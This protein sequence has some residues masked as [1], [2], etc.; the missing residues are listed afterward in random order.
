MPVRNASPSFDLLDTKVRRWVWKQG[1]ASLNQLQEKAIPK[2]LA[3]EGDVILAAPTAGGKTE[4]AFLPIISELCASPEALCVCVSPLKALI[5]DQ[6]DRL[7]FLCDDCGVPAYKWHGEAPQSLK[8]R[9]LAERCGLLLITPESLEAM[10]VRRGSE[11]KG[12]FGSLEFVVVDELHVFFASQR[13]KQLQ[14]LLHRLEVGIGRS[15]PRIALSATLGDDAAAS[16]FL[17]PASLQ[18]SEIVSVGQGGRDLKLLQ[19]GYRQMEDGRVVGSNSVAVGDTA[20]ASEYADPVSEEL[21]QVMRGTDNLVFANS[22]ERSEEFADQL[23]Q[24]SEDAGVPNE[25]LVHHGSLGKDVREYV[26]QRLKDPRFPTTVFATT[27]LEMGIDVGSVRSIAQIGVPPSVASLT[28]RLGRSG[29]SSGTPSILRTYVAEVD[30][31]EG[32]DISDLLRVSTIQV[33]AITELLLEYR[34]EPPD[35]AGLHL[36]TLLQQL[37]ALIVQYGGITAKDGWDVL[38]GSG[39]FQLPAKS[40]YFA[41]LKAM[42]GAGL[43]T[44]MSDGLLVLGVVGERLVEHYDFFAVFF[45]PDELTVM[46]QGQ[47]IGRVDPQGSVAPGSYIVLAGRRWEVTDVDVSVGVVQVRPARA[48]RAPRF[49]GN[50]PDVHTIVRKKMRAIYEGNAVPPYLDSMARAFL[51]EGRAAYRRNGLADAHFIGDDCGARLFPWVGDRELRTIGFA[52]QR[53]DPGLEREG[54][55][56]RSRLSKTDLKRTCAALVDEGFPAATELLERFPLLP[57]NKYDQFL[58]DDLLL[59]ETAATL[60]DT[61]AAAIALR[62]VLTWPN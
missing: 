29:R 39:V 15:V 27:T 58:T 21:F 6:Y 20:D 45:A 47:L 16:E 61:E 5:N 33:I 31:T 22:R 23:R 50:L 13:G 53:F 44:Q 41:L 51:D 14:A 55:Y 34:V 54:V 43:I 4:A 42:G 8:R 56:L 7:S 60:L 52:L 30:A 28:Q 2:I 19:R 57:I 36:S 25:F 9:F 46:H 49:G 40:T 11:A 10:L 35:T 3:R 59:E 12:I 37:L 17:R 24:M 38:C 48:G 26:E 18:R 62:E 32:A 1:W